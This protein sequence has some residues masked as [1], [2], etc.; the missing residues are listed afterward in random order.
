MFLA[1]A[2]PSSGSWGQVP[3]LARGKLFSS[4]WI[5]TVNW[6]VSVEQHCSYV[7]DKR[8]LCGPAHGLA[9]SRTSLHRF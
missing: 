9:P 7:L 1:T 2:F 3:R 8:G 6:S 4:Q 5:N